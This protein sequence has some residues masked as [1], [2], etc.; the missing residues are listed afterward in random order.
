M[1]FLFLV[2]D[3]VPVDLLC[4]RLLLS[5]VELLLS[6]ACHLGNFLALF[7]ALSLHL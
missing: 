2:D 3:F 4:G 7:G 1:F 5:L 6:P